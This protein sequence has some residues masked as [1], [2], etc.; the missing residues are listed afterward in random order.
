MKIMGIDQS[1]TNTGVVVIEDGKLIHKESIKIKKKGIMRLHMICNKLEDIIKK[2]VPDIFVMEGYA[3]G[4]SMSRVFDL[5]ELGGIIKIRIFNYYYNFD[6][7]RNV[8]IAP[9][10]NV[11]FIVPPTMLKKFVTGKGNCKKALMLLKIYKKWGIEF[12]DDNI[13]D[14]F[15]LAKFIERYLQS[16]AQEMYILKFTKTEEEIFKKYKK[17]RD[18]NPI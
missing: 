1:L 10:N 17:Y 6:N 2:Y 8:T 14:A 11:F 9:F 18:E 3:Y 4:S 5:G 13:A 16:N 15:A 7:P 12:N